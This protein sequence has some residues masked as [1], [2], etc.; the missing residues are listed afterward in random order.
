MYILRFFAL[1]T[2]LVCTSCFASQT[3]ASP[4]TTHK[5]YSPPKKTTTK[6]ASKKKTSSVAAKESS[7]KTTASKKV[8]TTKKKTTTKR[9]ASKTHR[10]KTPQ[11]RY[12]ANTTV[13]ESE[14]ASDLEE[15]DDEPLEEEPETSEMGDIALSDLSKKGVTTKQQKLLDAAF[16]YLG[17]P[18]LYGGM[19]RSGIDCSGFVGSAFK[20]VDIPLHRSSRDMSTQ[21]KKVSLKRLK[22]GDLLF[23]KTGRRNRIS[24]VG[25]V[26]DVD[27]EEVKFIHSST[28]RGVVISS[29]S[30]KYYKKAFRFAKRVM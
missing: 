3:S 12:A 17:T 7:T 22:V 16:S 23:F 19:S 27:E 8:A 14:D 10:P 13:A 15:D 1:F 6:V 4:L 21:G 30:E 18:Y 24:H 20:S 2:L 26:V 29:L 11:R 9:Y 25:M 5:T 28:K